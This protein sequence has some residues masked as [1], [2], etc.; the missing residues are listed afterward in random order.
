MI[1]GLQEFDTWKIQSTIA[2]NFICSKNA[3]EERLM[4][5]KGDNIRF[6]CVNK[7]VDKFF[8]SLCLRYQDNLQTSME[9]SQ[10]VF[11]SVELMYYK[12]HKANFWRGSS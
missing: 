6:N 3:E 11:D 2:I 5:S 4:H 7:V 10:F 1:I 12:C 9:G 8:E